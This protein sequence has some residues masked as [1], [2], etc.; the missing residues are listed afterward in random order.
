MFAVQEKPFHIGFLVVLFLFIF[1]CNNSKSA[2]GAEKKEQSS[3]LKSKL[4]ITNQSIGVNGKASSMAVQGDSVYISYFDSKNSD[5]KFV[6]SDDLGVTFK[7]ENVRTIDSDGNVGSF[8]SIAVLGDEIFVSFY[9]M[10]KKN[11]KFARS[12]DRGRTWP[13]KNIVTVD[14]KS[15]TGIFNSI[16]VSK[17][18][19]YISYTN[20]TKR[21]VCVARSL[22]KG[23]TWDSANIATVDDTAVSLGGWYTSIATSGDAV[24][25][26]YN[27]AYHKRGAGKS[28]RF[29]KSLDG[30][31]TWKTEHIKN[32]DGPECSLGH[33]TSI[34]VEDEKVYISYVSIKELKVAVS[35]D[36]GDTWKSSDIKVIDLSER[37]KYIG[38][39]S[40]VAKNSK[41]YIS[42]EYIGNLTLAI[43][44]DSGST[45]KKDDIV[46]LGE[47]SNDIS[48]GTGRRQPAT[49]IAI[50]GSYVLIANY[51]NEQSELKLAVVETK[52]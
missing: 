9:D 35:R 18:N 33:F 38:S 10:S 26:S 30:G 40:V 47:I 20:E 44:E 37:P 16:A 2:L 13:A 31:V 22:D 51:D 29:A 15:D 23:A 3:E 36:L 34:D 19:V 32:V 28:L 49:K 42:Y 1:S 48:R 24:F 27:G 14:S 43:S 7:K 17:N 45:W 4:P 25:I 12:S 50:T 46:A 11:L 5:L 6:W 52:N 41:V 21:S 39:T 8:S